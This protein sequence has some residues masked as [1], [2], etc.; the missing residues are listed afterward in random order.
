MAGY[1]PSRALR[2]S[3]ELTFNAVFNVL[4]KTYFEVFTRYFL[5][6]VVLIPIE[7]MT[8][9]F[10][11]CILHYIAK[12]MNTSLC[13]T[14]FI[15]CVRYVTKGK[16]VYPHLLSVRVHQLTLMLNGTSTGV[17]TCPQIVGC[18][19]NLPVRLHF[20]TKLFT[21]ARLV[22]AASDVE[23]LETRRVSMLTV[24]LTLT[25]VSRC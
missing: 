12:F 10:F 13:Y 6:A 23:I 3:G 18:L 1:L 19:G 2:P 24:T 15:L 9:F 8:I 7:T 17:D 20:Y 11:R 14:P 16:T 21:V 25:L 22:Q 4:V 5:T